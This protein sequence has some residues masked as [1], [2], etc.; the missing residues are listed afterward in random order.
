MKFL[1]KPRGQVRWRIHKVSRLLEGKS[2]DT[3]QSVRIS[4]SSMSIRY[5]THLSS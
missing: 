3:D 5:I 4:N 1:K 2:P